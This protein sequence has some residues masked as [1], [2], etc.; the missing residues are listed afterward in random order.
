MNASPV[1][2]P[3]RRALCC[4]CGTLR[5]TSGAPRNHQPEGESPERIAQHLKLLAN[6]RTK[7]EERARDYWA[8]VQPWH[9]NLE[10]LRCATCG[11]ITRH[12]S[13]RDDEHRNYAEELDAV[14]NGWL[15]GAV[16][17]LEGIGAR[18]RVEEFA[19]D[20]GRPASAE[21][22]RYLDDGAVF[23]TLNPAIHRDTLMRRVRDIYSRIANPDRAQWFVGTTDD[24]QIPYAVV[25]WV[26]S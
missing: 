26:A 8:T 13:I 12:A 23:V 9:R 17:A 22:I 18:V 16:R 3:A 14:S 21:V 20:D 11:T 10:D 24:G 4:E 7:A 15:A 2:R 5:T 6:P 19:L 25:A 1:R